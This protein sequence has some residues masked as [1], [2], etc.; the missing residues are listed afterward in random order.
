[1]KIYIFGNGNI[2]F[3]DFTTF[4][5]K[6]LEPFFSDQ[7]IEFILCDFRGTDTLAMELLKNITHKVSIYHIG[8]KPRYYPDVYKTQVSQWTRKGGFIS[9]EERDSTA[10]NDCTHFLAKD[11]N[12]NAKKV[13]GSERNIIECLKKGKIN[14]STI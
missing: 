1:M 14:L 5:K 4:Y 11:F 13:S 6:P 12:S 2:H 10:I 8:E 7:N 3:D 9:D